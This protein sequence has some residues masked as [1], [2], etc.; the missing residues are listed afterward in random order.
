MS[1]NPYSLLFG[2]E[3]Q[4]TI[5]RAAQMNEII[6]SFQADIPSQQ[7]YMIT[8]VRGCGKTVFMTEIAKTLSQDDKWII[9][10]L[11]S[12]QDLLSDLAAALASENH[13]AQLFQKSSINL[14][15]FG[16][17]LEV[18]GSVPITNIQ[19]AITKMLESIKKNGKRV[20]ICIDEVTS[21]D[22]M[23]AFAS[24]Y[25]IFVRQDLPLFL[26]M[27]GLFENINNL[28]NEK[29]LTFLYRAPKVELKP[30][31]ITT[32]S[33][34]YKKTFSLD[35]AAGLEMAKM[36][37]GYSFAFQV[38]GYFT[39][40]E[41]GDY[42]AALPDYQ[43]Y[44]EDYVYEKIWSELSSGD[45]KLAYGI[46]KSETGKASEIKAELSIENNEYTPYRDRLIKRGI[47]DGSEHGHLKF[48]LPLFEQYVLN[49]YY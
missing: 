11:N 44:L 16:I 19:V 9:V 7:I 2:K 31:N 41:N 23:R 4:Q 45:R 21:T 46:A 43:Q 24:A 27:T 5:S 34:N 12:S 49:N 35:A 32:I 30:L 39:W 40:K 15:F 10:E 36:T 3:P 18:K 25:Q 28:Q 22:A 6:D 26:I 14:S 47:I 38:L 37:K 17:G 20:L 8:G 1:Q 42:K 29:N 48:I 33:N 13:L